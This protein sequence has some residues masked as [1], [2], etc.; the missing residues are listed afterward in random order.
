MFPSKKIF[1]ERGRRRDGDERMRSERQG[2][3]DV[4]GLG[5][6]GDDARNAKCA[7]SYG[8]LSISFQFSFLAT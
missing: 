8:E 2:M 4:S 6:A 3:I 5:S 7:E 1:P